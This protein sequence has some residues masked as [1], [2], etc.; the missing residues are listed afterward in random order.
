MNC[1]MLPSLKLMKILLDENIPRHLTKELEEHDVTTVQK[2]GWSALENG[3]LLNKAQMTFDV[4]I[5]ADKNIE[6]QQH[7][8]G[9]NIAIIV[10]RVYRRD[11]KHI[12]PLVPQIKNALQRISMHEVVVISEYDVPPS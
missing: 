9:F 7:L 10:I 8:P 6:F 5:T 3:A 1:P 2:M 12:L 11:I 4:M